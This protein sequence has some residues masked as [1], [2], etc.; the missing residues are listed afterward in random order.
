MKSYDV[1]IIGGGPAGFSAGIYAGRAKLST[2]IIEGLQ[3]GG[4][5][6]Q[7]SE[8]ANYPGSLPVESGASLAE[9]M[10][11]Q[12]QNFGCELARDTITGVELEGP[13]KRLTGEKD[14]Y[15]C[16][17]LIIATGASPSKIGCP[18]EQEF[19]G[20]GVSYCA[21]CDG[22]FFEGLPVYV[23][24]GGD[25]AVEEALYLTRFARKVTLIHRRDRLRAALSIQ[26]KAFA[27]P[28]L[29]F[30]W[31]SRVKEISGGFSV[32]RI[33]LEDVRDGK[34]TEIKAS[35]EDGMLGLF[36]FVGFT[37]A[38]GIFEGKLGMEKGYILTDED[39]RTSVPG[40]FAAGDCR[41]KSLRQVVTA[42]SDGA[43]AGWAAS[44][45]I[46]EA[47]GRAYN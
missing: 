16:R 46:D 7:T 1:I 26:E 47:L 18:G 35:E 41:K 2:L 8:I 3:E 17:A 30:I 24:G 42:A 10:C 32:D 45:Y 12:A 39:M 40:V 36:V 4:Q 33:V 34:L 44:K 14:S 5:I 20:M 38:T 37:P 19:T 43:I 21:T 25:A 22:A 29:D 11:S 6:V 13:L 27:E 15:E 23:V 9:R 31:N 28:K